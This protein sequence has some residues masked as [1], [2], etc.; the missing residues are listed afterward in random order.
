MK[1]VKI[2][3]GVLLKRL[4]I[5][6]CLLYIQ[7]W[8][9][10][11]FNANYF[12][13]RSLSDYFNII[14]QGA[15]FD[16][17]TV[18][19]FN[20]FFILMH[21]VPVKWNKPAYSKTLKVIFLI[22]NIFMLLLCNV[23]LAYYGFNN[24]RLTIDILALADAGAKNAISLIID[25]WYATIIWLASIYLL[26]RLYKKT[27]SSEE[28]KFKPIHWSLALILFGCLSFIGIRGGVQ[29]QGISP[30]NSADKVNPALSPLVTNSAFT[31]IFSTQKR[32]IEDRKYFTEAEM[33][34]KHSNIYSIN[35]ESTTHPNVVII[36]MESMARE[37]IGALNNGEGYTPFLDKLVANSYVF[38]N[39]YANAERSN[40]SICA[41]FG[42][43]PSLMDDAFMYS[44]YSANCVEGMGTKMKEMGYSTA[45]FHGGLNGEFRF[46]S[47]S[48]NAGFDNYYGKNEFNKD[49]Y[50][51]GHWGIY[52][53]KFFPYFAEELGKQKTPFC[54]AFF[55]ISSHHPFM[56]PDEFKGKFPKGTQ[57]IHESV[58][59]ADYSLGKFFEI[60]S[61]QSW[62]NNTLFIITGDHTF[63][64]NVHP[65]KYS[66]AVGRY[67]VPIILF[68]GDSSLRGQNDVIAQHV[69]II[70][71]LLDLTGYKGKIK[72]FGRSLLRNDRAPHAT[73]YAND[74]YR[75]IYKD[76][77]LMFDG[78]KERGFY[79]FKEDLEL[80]KDVGNAH[81]AE[82]KEA[83]EILK[84]TLQNYTYGLNHNRLCN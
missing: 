1:E 37:Y 34:S 47:F 29:Y 9:F 46:D 55:S 18:I 38:T 6:F 51:D 17:S 31:F 20:S 62:Y 39:A 73:M 8:I 4:I 14:L 59:Y 21:L 52:D 16:I 78:E 57:E 77:I 3:Y 58:G 25:F 2:Q 12:P 13:S 5:S 23:D 48:R 82:K 36:V 26:I 32:S 68:R 61:K 71:T 30:A 42:G 53:D 7:R 43:L 84:A 44:G 35:S 19:V 24:K 27:E 60:A 22:S 70:P 65:P 74:L 79:N 40:K 83:E 72:T 75:I 41:I 64:Y 81:P 80:K 49:E 63:G 33:Q 54:D 11:L 69:D 10:L 50:F 67:A 15:R 45:F 28:T 56:V 66:N 76:Y